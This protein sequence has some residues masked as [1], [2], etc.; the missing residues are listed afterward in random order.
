MSIPCRSLSLY[1]A[2]KVVEKCCIYFMEKK[3]GTMKKEKGN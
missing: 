2:V 1:F 3:G